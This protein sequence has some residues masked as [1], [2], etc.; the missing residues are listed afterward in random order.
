MC[1]EQ[2]TYLAINVWNGEKDFWM[3][4][5]GELMRVYVTRRY[6][7]PFGIIRL[8]EFFKEG[9]IN[10]VKKLTF[11]SKQ[12]CLVDREALSET[13]NCLPEF[14]GI[15]NSPFHEEPIFHVISIQKTAIADVLELGDNKHRAQ[16][17]VYV[18]RSNNLVPA[19]LIK[20]KS[21]RREHYR[22]EN[23]ENGMF[24]GISVTID[25]LEILGNG[26]IGNSQKLNVM[27][28]MCFNFEQRELDSNPMLSTG[29]I[30]LI[31]SDQGVNESS[32]LPQPKLQVLGLKRFVTEQKTFNY[33]TLFDGQLQCE[34]FCV[35]INLEKLISQNVIK[36]FTFITLL[37]YVVTQTDTAPF[38]FITN[39]KIHDEFVCQAIGE[40]PNAIEFL[41]D[42]KGVAN[43][44]PP[45][46]I[47]TSLLAGPYSAIIEKLLR[48][49]QHQQQP[50][51]EEQR[52]QVVDLS[53]NLFSTQK[54][55]EKEHR[56]SPT[57]EI[58]RSFHSLSLR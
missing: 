30:L 18:N 42:Q 6:F 7:N 32:E 55:Q 21:Y 43:P 9:R 8:D 38:I 50:T 52:K 53:P 54:S 51:N 28:D 4:G 45:N 14:L 26:I 2:K 37:N 47:T 29:F 57:S 36:V 40:P 33:L 44:R 5:D 13:T 41:A 27:D 17:F 22:Y 25:S 11:I 24:D 58:D 35:D 48:P 49:E 15:K 39:V 20:L 46:S 1:D 16:S 31:C 23:D 19:Q 56:L 3:Y 10:V 34:N 12:S